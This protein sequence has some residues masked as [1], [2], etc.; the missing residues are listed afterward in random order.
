MRTL[1]E[2]KRKLSIRDRNYS[3]IVFQTN[4]SDDKL[5]KELTEFLALMPFPNKQP[6][7]F[8]VLCKDDGKICSSLWDEFSWK[9]QNQVSSLE[10]LIIFLSTNNYDVEQPTEYML[11]RNPFQE[12]SWLVETVNNCFQDLESNEMTFPE[13]FST[14]MKD[15]EWRN[16]IEGPDFHSPSLSIDDCLYSIMY[17]FDFFGLFEDLDIDR[18]ISYHV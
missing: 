18:G 7:L 3:G 2:V 8:S 16:L 17:I 12:P 14:L 15:S 5:L 6:R 4:I 11:E 13:G 9:V 10:D 1:E